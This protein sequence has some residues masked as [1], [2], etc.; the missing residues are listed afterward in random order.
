MTP[1]TLPTPLQHLRSNLP[2]LGY[3]GLKVAA[4]CFII[5]LILWMAR[6]DQRL[7]VQ[8]VYSFGSGLV[9]WLI[10]DL[11]RFFIDHDSPYNWPRGWHG[12]ALIV[13]G[14]SVGHVIGTFIG[15]TYCGTSTW[16]LFHDKPRMLLNFF[17]LS[18]V[19]GGVITYFFYAHGKSHYLKSALEVS[20]RQAA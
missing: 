6:P 1:N 10:I 8:L 12:V 11:G 2:A 14:C 13:V 17:L 9:T 19:S 3:R 18:L 20:E 7:D 15:D 4:F 16:T 5:S